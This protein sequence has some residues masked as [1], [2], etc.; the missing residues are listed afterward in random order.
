MQTNARKKT[1]C[2]EPKGLHNTHE[3]NEELFKQKQTYGGLCGSGCVGGNGQGA[4]DTT[5]QKARQRKT[6]GLNNKKNDE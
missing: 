6:S 4:T 5:H 1:K 2:V 3:V